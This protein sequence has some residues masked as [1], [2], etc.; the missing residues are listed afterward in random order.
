MMTDIPQ[1]VEDLYN[2]TVNIPEETDWPDYLGGNPLFVRSLY[3]FYSGLRAGFQLADALREKP[4][5][6]AGE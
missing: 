2:E 6:P 3:A 1:I 4:F 5:I